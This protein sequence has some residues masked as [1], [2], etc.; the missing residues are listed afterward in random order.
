MKHTLS[1]YVY[2]NDKAQLSIAGGKTHK[3][4]RSKYKHWAAMTDVYDL[5][6][7]IN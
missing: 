7:I 1:L 2:A 5:M 4:S 6:E 3:S